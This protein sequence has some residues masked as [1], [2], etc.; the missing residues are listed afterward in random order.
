[1]NTDN[2]SKLISKFNDILNISKDAT[3]TL[4][5]NAEIIKAFTTI[6]TSPKIQRLLVV[7]MCVIIVNYLPIILQ[8]I[9]FIYLTS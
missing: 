5:E 3:A 1:M 9:A 2:S 4:K 8:V 7:G 6:L